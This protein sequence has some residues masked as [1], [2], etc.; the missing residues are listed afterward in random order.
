ML[1]VL[2]QLGPACGLHDPRRALYDCR[3]RNPLILIS[4]V[5]SLL[6]FVTQPW[7]PFPGSI[8]LKGLAVAPLA[9]LALRSP[10]PGRDGLFLG[11]ALAFGS[12]GDVLLDWNASLFPAG[13]GAFLIGHFF[14]LGLFWRNRPRPSSKLLFVDG[15]ILVILGFFVSL[16]SLYLLPATGQMA[17]AVAMYMGALTG[18]VASAVALQL[19]ECWVVLGALLFLFSDTVLA[20]GKFKSPV[21]G[22]EL[23]VWPTYYVRQLL[24]AV[25][26]LRAKTVGGLLDPHQ[27]GTKCDST[28]T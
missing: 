16:M 23:L 6:Y 27:R 7:H 3:V 26:Y 15:V 21:P 28:D 4:V 10:L 20:V 12:L 24:I 1:S 5:A 25:G 22:H 17:S 14:Y 2:P 13:L 8:V 18:M 9:L 11:L 19:P